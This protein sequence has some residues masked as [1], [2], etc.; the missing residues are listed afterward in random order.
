MLILNLDM[1]LTIFSNMKFL[2]LSFRVGRRLSIIILLSIIIIAI[3]FIVI[4]VIVI[5]ISS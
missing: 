4:I 3:V 1:Q 5:I 2:L